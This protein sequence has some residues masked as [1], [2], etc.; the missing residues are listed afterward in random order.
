MSTVLSAI[1]DFFSQM[2]GYREYLKQSVLRDLRTKYKRSLL[3]YVW[4]MLHP[5]AMMTVLAVVFSHIMRF[6]M[7][8][9][10]VFLFAG[11]LAWNFFNSTALMSLH[12][13]RANARLFEQVPVPKYIFVLS[14]TFSNLANLFFAMVPLLL[15][16]LAT[17]RPIH[18]TVFAFPVIV[19]PLFLVVVGVSLLLATS[20]V[21]FDDTLHLS[22]VALSMLYFLCPILY[23]RDLLPAHLIGYLTLNPLFY[24]IEFIR[25]LFYAGTLPDPQLFLL[26][27]AGSLVVLLVG[28]V[29]F[30]KA[31]DKFLYFL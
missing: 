19:I 17:G 5:L 4:T 31:E 20:N 27:L 25:D 12:S 10:A 11:L 30:K 26:N 7:K 3:G 8:D 16:M 24:Q 9:Y 6:E 13:I 18:W 2:Y 21:F 29:I 28:L 1:P 23:N 22:Q 14:I 15:I